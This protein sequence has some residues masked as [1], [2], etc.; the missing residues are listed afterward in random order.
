MIL[1]GSGATLVRDISPGRGS[2]VLVLCS[3]V[4]PLPFTKVPKFP[5][6]PF[7]SLP[8]HFYSR[9]YGPRPSY[10]SENKIIRQRHTEWFH[11]CRDRY[12]SA[13]PTHERPATKNPPFFFLLYWQGNNRTRKMERHYL[14]RKDKISQRRP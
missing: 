5:K 8:F 10:N 2:H 3:F 1:A 12:E 6:S 11:Y 13:W 4:L 9:W 14:H 7:P